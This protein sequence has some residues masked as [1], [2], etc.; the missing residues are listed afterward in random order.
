MSQ[1]E[2]AIKKRRLGALEWCLIVA[3]VVIVLGVAVRM[4][5]LR[6]F[7]PKEEPQLTEYLVSFRVENIRS[8]SADLF[9]NGSAFYLD[10][11]GDVF[12]TIS[13]SVATTPAE[14][15][16]ENED[17]EY[18]LVYYSDDG[19]DSRVDVSGTFLVKASV[20]EDKGLYMLNGEHYIAP[21][22]TLKLYSGELTVSI[23]VTDITET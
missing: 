10:D 6:L 2:N 1:A 14:I 17:G 22:L 4:N 11:S 3:S 13:G 23:L 5:V 15:Y 21:N 8:T 20:S 19:D 7:T 16:L 9:E 12:G 18:V